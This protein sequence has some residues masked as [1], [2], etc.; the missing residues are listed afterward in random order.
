[1]LNYCFEFFV[2]H[3]SP[4]KTSILHLF[5]TLPALITVCS[6]TYFP[7]LLLIFLPAIL[8]ASTAIFSISSKDTLTFL[9]I[10]FLCYSFYI[11][12][13]FREAISHAFPK[14]IS[15]I[16]YNSDAMAN[17]KSSLDAMSFIYC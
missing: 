9:W 13:I 12:S 8:I 7:M 14:D 2:V 15:S 4:S 6:A 11:S 16:L 10:F 3:F 1:M 5:T 17:L